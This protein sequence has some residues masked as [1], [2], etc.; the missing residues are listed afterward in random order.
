M[1]MLIDFYNYR[2]NSEGNLFAGS[3]SP[4]VR[5]PGQE[6]DILIWIQTYHDVWWQKIFGVIG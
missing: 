2:R 3:E 1:G 6:Y 5:Y 4:R